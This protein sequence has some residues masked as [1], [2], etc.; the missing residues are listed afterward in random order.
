MNKKNP[1]KQKCV[2][3]NY[4]DEGFPLVDRLFEEDMMNDLEKYPRS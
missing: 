2:T 3:V 4:R 1:E